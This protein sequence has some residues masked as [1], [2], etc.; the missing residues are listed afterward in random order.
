MTLV[1][2]CGITNIEDAK[3][4]ADLGADMIGLN[5]YR[6]S[7]RYV[8]LHLAKEIAEEVRGRVKL[9]GVFV[10]ETVAN[11]TSLARSVGLDAVQLHGDETPEDVLE[12][13]D[14]CPTKVIK[15]LRPRREIDL[16]VFHRYEAEGFLIDSCSDHLYGGTGKVGNWEIARKAAVIFPRVIL[17]GGLDPGNL[18]SA[19]DT[20]RP[21]AVDVAG[22]VELVKGRKD[23]SKMGEFIRIAKQT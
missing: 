4:A 2:I 23:P 1:K 8:P 17:A 13:G 18:R 5:F 11:V 19:I 9:V 7:P 3:V 6:P 10:N 12:V 16:R 15:A 22:G 20:V 14:K 21:F